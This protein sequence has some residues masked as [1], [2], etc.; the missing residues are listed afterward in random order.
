MNLVYCFN[1][2]CYNV[3][4]RILKGGDEP[5]ST[6]DFSKTSKWYSPNL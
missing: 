4:D 6:I 5:M 3:A 2:L 1:R